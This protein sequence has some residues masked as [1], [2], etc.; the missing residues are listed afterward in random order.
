MHGNILFQK[1]LGEIESSLVLPPDQHDETPE[2]TLR[3]L[4]H[5][6]AG[7][8]CSAKRA[9]SMDIVDLADEQTSVLYEYISRRLSGVPLMQVT[10]RASFMGLELEFAP[11]VFMVRPETELLGRSAVGLLSAMPKPVMIDVGCGSGNLT[12]GIASSLSGL[13]VFAV[14]ILQ[15]CV[16]L[17]NRN[18]AKSDLTNQVTVLLGDL[19]EPLEAMGL[20]G[21]VDAVVCNP[22]YI[23]SGRLKG[24]RAY[25]VTHEPLEAFDGGPFGFRMHQRLISESLRFLKP[26]GSLLFEFGAG[27]DKQIL[28][29]FNRAG[30]Y[31]PIDFRVDESGTARVVIARRA[32]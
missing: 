30:G 13:T 2:S 14:D 29:L 24:D 5:A 27:Q 17:T 3:A 32:E 22:P 23:A 21:D 8:P 10:C 12:C 11:D 6:A 7:N 4:W 9:S 20:Q 15:S 19:F 25:L 18:V 1:L 28:G 16:A 26:G 31:G